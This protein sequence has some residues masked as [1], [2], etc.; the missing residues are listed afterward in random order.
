M[1]IRRS[2]LTGVVAVLFGLASV[3]STNTAEADEYIGG[4]QKDYPNG[5]NYGVISVETAVDTLKSQKAFVE[6]ASKEL[7][8]EFKLF[9]AAEYAGIVNGLA[10]GQVQVGWL[11]ASSYASTYMDCQCVEPIAGAQNLQG[12]MG[13]NSVLIV[14][15][16]SPY[17]KY[18]DLK[19]K[20]V[21]RGEPHSTSGWLIPTVAWAERGD[22][23]DKYY[24]APLSGGHQQTIAGVL[25]GTFDGGFTWTTMGDGFGAI[26]KML[27]KGMM[28]RDEIRVIW[29]SS[30]V[31]TPP[32]TIQ[33][34]LP[35]AMKAD[36]TKLFLRL[37]ENDPKMAEA[38]AQGKS[39]GMQ[40]VYHEDYLAVIQAKEWV[41]ANRKKK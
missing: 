4:W 38:V 16:D 18:E 19:G 8:V 12:G 31:P 7:G 3:F 15:S 5:I 29:T 39:L 21:A 11:G 33:K 9:T 25:N 36:L 26:R 2:I 32:V 41:K 35:I 6:Y 20:T 27:D 14:K 40:R 30:L 37:E 17:M 13:Y 24:N 23:I 1:I 22:P 34:N 28:K 10:A